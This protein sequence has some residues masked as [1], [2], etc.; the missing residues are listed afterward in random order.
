MLLFVFLAVVLSITTFATVFI[1]MFHNEIVEFLK[2]K[3]TQI[4]TMTEII[5]KEK[6]KDNEHSV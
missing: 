2:A 3:A 5:K 6:Q 4:H 1:F